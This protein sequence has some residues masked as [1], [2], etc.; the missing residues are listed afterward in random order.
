MARATDF[1]S[2]RSNSR[3][4]TTSTTRPSTDCPKVVSSSRTPV[5]SPPLASVRV[6]RI[7]ATARS[8]NSSTANVARPPS[9]CRRRCSASAGITR[10][11]DDSARAAPTVRAAGQGAP[12]ANAAA[13]PSARQAATCVPPRPNTSRRISRSR[14]HDSSS[15]IMNSRNTTPSSAI[16]EISAGRETVRYPSHGA[17]W[18]KAP[19]PCGPSATPASMKPRIGLTFSRLNNGTTTPAVARNSTTSL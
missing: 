4:A 14:S 1:S 13:A 11:V 12:R 7:G 19:R 17:A 6:I 3:P 2:G 8:W 9:P 16:S 18:V 15:P 5:P 10:A